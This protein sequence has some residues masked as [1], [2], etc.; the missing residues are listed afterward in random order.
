[1]GLTPPTC[2]EKAFSSFQAF[3]SVMAAVCV[4]PR[5][6]DRL[7]HP[8]FSTACPALPVNSETWWRNSSS[9][10]RSLCW[11]LQSTAGQE[12]S[13][14][15]DAAQLSAT[16]CITWWELGQSRGTGSRATLAQ[17]LSLSTKLGLGALWAQRGACLHHTAEALPGPFPA[18]N[19]IFS[20][21]CLKSLTDA[22]WRQRR[23][24]LSSEGT[25]QLLDWWNQRLDQ[26]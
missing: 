17:S 23:L 24:Y 25:Q 7:A 5:E 3:A 1:M 22:S 2:L 16:W 9:T 13:R 12:E 15:G 20:P 11:E 18:L 14:G 19:R 21:S 6:D 26:G 4:F 10:G 8:S